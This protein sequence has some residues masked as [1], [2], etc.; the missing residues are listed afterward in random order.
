MKVVVGKGETSE[1]VDK[2]EKLNTE[3]R[4]LYTEDEFLDMIKRYRKEWDAYSIPGI[5][6]ENHCRMLETFSE[7]L[8]HELATNPESHA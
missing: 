6:C 8:A 7:Y 5:Y 3:V 1:G 2:N 4:K